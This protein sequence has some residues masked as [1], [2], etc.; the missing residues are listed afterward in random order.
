MILLPNEVVNTNLINVT[1]LLLVFFSLAVW[2]KHSQIALSDSYLYLTPIGISVLSILFVYQVGSGEYLK[3]LNVDELVW[4]QIVLS[5][6]ILSISLMR[7]IRS[8]KYDV[9][10]LFSQ[11]IGICSL[12]LLPNWK[13]SQWLQ[14]PKND[15]YL[16]IDE[17]L[18]NV[19]FLAFIVFSIVCW[20]KHKDI[21]P[22]VN[23]YQIE[24][25]IGIIAGLILF[26]IFPNSYEDLF[27]DKFWT[28]PDYWVISTSIL[29]MGIIV[30]LTSN[31]YNNN[32]V[33]FAQGVCLFF[34]GYQDIS[35]ALEITLLAFLAYILV[36]SIRF[37]NQ[38]SFMSAYHY[39]LNSLVAAYI[40]GNIYI[41]KFSGIPHP[42]ILTSFFIG[43]LISLYLM[44]DQAGQGLHVILQSIV[45]LLFM[46]IPFTDRLIDLE[47][48]DSDIGP[49]YISIVFVAYMIGILSMWY[50]NKE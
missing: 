28:S 29:L 37:R 30:Y 20:W 2:I 10:V 42:S 7:Y 27:K 4:F 49:R 15:D 34:L 17:Y 44:K 36:M 50:R 23:L 9:L 25:T 14:N 38:P 43:S 6:G 48:R 11:A 45:V 24:Y 21:G 41:G 3:D 46:L 16:K 33:V 22:E 35:D 26:I 31:S 40:V 18:I 39:V 1:Y 19:I 5:V 13:D 8:S 47:I 32:V 12:L